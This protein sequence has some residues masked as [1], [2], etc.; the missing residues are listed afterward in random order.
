MIFAAWGEYFH[1]LSLYL[2]FHALHE[3][4]LSRARVLNSEKN[5]VALQFLKGVVLLIS[6]FILFAAHLNFDGGVVNIYIACV[7]IVYIFSVAL[8]GIYSKDCVVCKV[9]SNR[10]S[11]MIMNYS[12][13]FIINSLVGLGVFYIDRIVLDFYGYKDTIAENS[14]VMELV[15]QIIIFPVNILSIYMYRR[16]IEICFDKKEYFRVLI[17]KAALIS[18][19]VLFSLVLFWVF[20]AF[21]KVH[22]FPGSYLGYWDGNWIFAV[23]SISAYCLKVYLF[24]QFFL[25]VDRRTYVVFCNFIFFSLYLVSLISTEFIFGKVEV[26]GSLLFSSMVLNSLNLV[27]FIKYFRKCN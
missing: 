15:K 11:S 3:Y 19:F 9:A 17:N 12:S 22:Y 25:S 20:D 1:I 26:F 10:R 2:L 6:V 16:E 21:L 7:V 14:A 8:I 4:L 24:D 13:L 27:S 18:C 5:Y 23:L